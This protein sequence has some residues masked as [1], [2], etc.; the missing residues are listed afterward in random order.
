[1]VD[2]VL[3]IFDMEGAAGIGAA[4]QTGDDLIGQVRD[5]IMDA[6]RSRGSVALYGQESLGQ[7]YG[8]LPGVKGRHRA[9]AAYKLVA[10]LYRRRHMFGTL[11]EGLMGFVGAE[12]G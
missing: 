1:M 9:V 8:Y 5:N 11:G 10:G 4:G 2:L 3:N 12:F 6:P 7:G